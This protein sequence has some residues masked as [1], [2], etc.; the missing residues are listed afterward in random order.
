MVGT[1]SRH[2]LWMH[3]NQSFIENKNAPVARHSRGVGGW[4]APEA[5]LMSK[6]ASMWR[7]MMTTHS[8]SRP[9][10][11][12]CCNFCK[13]NTLLQEYDNRQQGEGGGG[14]GGPEAAPMPKV[15]SMRPKMMTTHSTSRPEE[16]W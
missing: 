16:M 4:G 8:M 13:G 15:A 1:A 9:L 6:V 12:Q 5:A 3:P 11:E 7:N 14:G 2:V 10:A